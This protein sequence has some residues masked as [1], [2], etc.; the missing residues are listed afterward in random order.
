MLILNVGRYGIF[1][2]YPKFLSPVQMGKKE[3]AVKGNGI[4]KETPIGFPY[5]GL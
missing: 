3:K 1:P 2:S 5:W 4:T